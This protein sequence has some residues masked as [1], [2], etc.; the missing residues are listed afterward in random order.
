V[1]K[2]S[3]TEADTRTIEFIEKLTAEVGLNQ[4][5]REYG[6]KES[7]IDA[8]AEQAILDGCHQTNPVPVT[9]ADLKALY[10][11]AL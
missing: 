7:Q 11:A 4:K 5:L 3:D 2:C 9:K 6:V 10:R 1:V 8:L